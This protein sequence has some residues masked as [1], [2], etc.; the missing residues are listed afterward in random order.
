[1]STAFNTLTRWWREFGPK[2]PVER[3]ETARAPFT[4]SIQVRTALG[5]TYR[6]FGRDL[7]ACGMG[8]IVSA[9]L[10]VADPVVIYY[11]HP[12]RTGTRFLCRSGVVRWRVGSRYGFE[13]ERSLTD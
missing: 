4:A 8:A 1:M 10:D 2:P 5:I 6:G 13:F 7:S 9:D 12:T 3:R 11:T